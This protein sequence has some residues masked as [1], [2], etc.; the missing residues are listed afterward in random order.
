MTLTA[1][2]IKDVLEQQFAGCLGQSA[3]AT[4]IMLPSGRLQVHA[5]TAP[6]PAARASAEVTLRRGGSTETLVDAGGKVLDPGK[7]YRVTVNSFMAAGG[8]G[9]SVFL[10]GQAAVGG[11]QDIDAL[12]AHL[13]QFKAPRPAYA[14]LMHADDQGSPRIRR[15][16]GATCPLGA[17]V[18]P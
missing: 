7:A 15:S 9:F 12:V 10:K 11:A 13:A 14:P 5:G 3:S 8:D 18:N 4:R 6:R 2:D 17:Q 16:G 1:Q